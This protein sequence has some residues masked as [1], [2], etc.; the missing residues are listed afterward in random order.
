MISFRTDSNRFHLRAGAI[1]IDREHVLLHRLEGDTFWALPGGRI[2]A[3]E[4]G[5]EA[6]ER[7]FLEELGLSVRCE[8]LLCVGENFFEYGRE[9]HHEI[10]LYFSVMLPPGAAINDHGTTHPGLEGDR[11]LEFRW[12][13]LASLRDLDLRPA[14]LRD[15]LAQGDVPPHFVQD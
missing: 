4:Q 15:A 12:F 2:N 8:E 6:I 9:P 3:G 11:P 7:E 10:G 14:A 1:V 5:R 13:P